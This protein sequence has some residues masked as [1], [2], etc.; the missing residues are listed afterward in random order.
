[1]PDDRQQSPD[2]VDAAPP[3][4]AGSVSRRR[5]LGAAAG[6]AVVGGVGLA[7]TASPAGAD[8]SATRRLAVGVGPQ[9]ATTV[10]FRGRIAQTGA[11]GDLFT[12]YGYLTRATHART[13]HLFHG[14]PHNQS[15][16][17][18]TAYATGNLSA[19]I[20]DQSVHELDIVGTLTVFQRKHPG[21]HFNDPASFKVGKPVARFDL[22]LQDILAVYAQG[23]GIPT[24]TGDMRQTAAHRLAGGLAGHRFGHKGLRL[25]MFA[26]GLGTLTDPVTLNAELEIAGNWSVE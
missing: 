18:L 24:L 23:K 8:D 4:T 25:R 11:S 13:A 20:L 22:R 9:G 7:H 16:A 14:T 21:A 6:S 3:G 26:T 12:S 10:E 15:S 5:L 1:M 19:R 17:L 2:A